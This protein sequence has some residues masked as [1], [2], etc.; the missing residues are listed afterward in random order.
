M[1]FRE[2]RTEGGHVFLEIKNMN[3]KKGRI[4][5]FLYSFLSFFLSFCHLQ[6]MIYT[7]KGK[8]KEKKGNILQETHF[9]LSLS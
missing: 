8:G 7:C 9:S 4:S 2:C 5:G 3:E 6:L 1:V